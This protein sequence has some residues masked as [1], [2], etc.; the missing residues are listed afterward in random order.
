MKYYQPFSLVVWEGPIGL[1]GNNMK[2][3]HDTLCNQ[4]DS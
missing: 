1:H 4:G 3:R 2:L